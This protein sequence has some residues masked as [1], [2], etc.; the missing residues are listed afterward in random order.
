MQL[1]RFIFEDPTAYLHEIQRKFVHAFG[2]SISASSICRTLKSM[3]CSR[4]VV[5]HIAMQ[6]SDYQRAKFMAEI[7][8]YNPGMFIWLDES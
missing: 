1:L 5:R 6:Q 4:Q 2:V 8:L 7:C 3:G